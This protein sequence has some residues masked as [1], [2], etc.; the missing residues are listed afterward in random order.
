MRNI[1]VLFLLMAF[2]LNL[3]MTA[4]RNLKRYRK[5]RGITSFFPEDDLDGDGFIG[6]SGSDNQD[7]SSVINDLVSTPL[8][9]ASHNIFIPLLA[10]WLYQHLPPFGWYYMGARLLFQPTGPE[11][12]VNSKG[13]AIQRRTPPVVSH[14]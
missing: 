9:K 4:S 3:S 10:H 1:Y 2:A 12:H 7:D 6:G 5:D 11:G 14:E 8:Q 13:S